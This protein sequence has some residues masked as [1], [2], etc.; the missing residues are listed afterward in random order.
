LRD[1]STM[2]G[3]IGRSSTFLSIQRI[4]LATCAK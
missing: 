3:M 2:F 4:E 1:I